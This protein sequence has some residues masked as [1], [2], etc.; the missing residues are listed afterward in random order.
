M[1]FDAQDASEVEKEFTGVVGGLLVQD[2]DV[3]VESPADW[4][5]V[6]ERQPSKQEWAAM[7]FA[8]KSSK[9]VK[10]NGIIITNDKMTLGVGPGKPT[11]WRPFVS[12]SNRPKTVWRAVLAS[13]LLPIC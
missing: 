5:V 13:D 2:Q 3:V 7:E 10:S 1:A 11:V 12:L 9:Y 8:W 4:E 6:T